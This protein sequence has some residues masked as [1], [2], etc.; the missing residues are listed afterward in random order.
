MSDVFTPLL[1]HYGQLLLRRAATA[2]EEQLAGRDCVLPLVGALNQGL[3][4]VRADDA[5][6]ALDHFTE[7]GFL[8]ALNAFPDGEPEIRILDYVRTQRERLTQAAAE[9]RDDW[10][11]R[12]VRHHWDRALR[13]AVSV[14]RQIDGLQTLG[15]EATDADRSCL[16]AQSA[17]VGNYS[18][19]LL[20]AAG[21]LPSTDP[22]A[23]P[24][25][26]PAA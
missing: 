17:D 26:L 22:D 2:G 8:L 9:G 11:R 1:S 16:R 23:V 4:A 19:F 21:L 18:L 25:D 14:A 10:H 6:T 5:D 15:H 20:H 12:T 7:A 13:N 24:T 3:Q